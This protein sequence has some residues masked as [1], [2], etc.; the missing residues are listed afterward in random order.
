MYLNLFTKINIEW[1]YGIEEL[2]TICSYTYFDSRHLHLVYL[3][4]ASKNGFK[5]LS[6]RSRYI[7]YIFFEVMKYEQ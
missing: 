6:S 5:N 2:L 3:L 1:N 7:G 4:Y